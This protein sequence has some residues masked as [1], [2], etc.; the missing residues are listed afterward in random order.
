MPNWCSTNYYVK[1]KNKNQLFKFYLDCVIA[2]M[3]GNW[4][5]YIYEQAGYKTEKSKSGC[6]IF[7]GDAE[8]WI[9]CRGHVSNIVICGNPG[10]KKEITP[11]DIGDGI[12]NDFSSGF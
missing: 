4:L 6:T 11:D 1:G 7:S 3:K 9:S 12:D 8:E 5:G 10:T 2:R